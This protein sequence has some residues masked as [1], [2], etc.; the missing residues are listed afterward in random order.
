MNSKLKKI[1]TL[2]SSMSV[3]A[4]GAASVSALSV[5]N[6][7]A[8]QSFIS[9]IEDSSEKKLA[10]LLMDSGTS[11]AETQ[12]VLSAY[13]AGQTEITARTAINGP[14]ATNTNFYSGVNC[15][16]NQHYGVIIKNN[17]STSESPSLRLGYNSTWISFP[18]G[19]PYTELNGFGPLSVSHVLNSSQWLIMGYVEAQTT[20]AVPVGMLEIPFNV[21]KVNINQEHETKSESTVYHKF[22]F[23]RLFNYPISGPDTT[24]SYETY[25]LGDVNHDGIVTDVDVTYLSKY[26]VGDITDL[27]FT[28]T[29]KGYN[30]A[31]IVNNLAM[32]ANKDGVIGLS[33]L[34]TIL[35]SRE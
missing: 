32:D 28:Y 24:Y 22:T 11:I 34:A 8:N 3:L 29:D 12:D 27:S 25:V 7:N 10:K 15:S 1:I 5:D 16:S 35:Q 33:D 2:V 6:S 18:S 20:T 14:F 9:S 23:E 17:G 19:S 31:K 26:L 13:E 30:T 21:N 4:S